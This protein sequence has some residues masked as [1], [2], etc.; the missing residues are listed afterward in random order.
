MTEQTGWISY[1]LYGL[2]STIFWNEYNKKH[3]K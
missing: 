2:F 3:R 1:L